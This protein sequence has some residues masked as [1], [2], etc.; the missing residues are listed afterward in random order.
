[1][2]RAGQR[3]RSQL[4][5]LDPSIVL[6]T[7]LHP[8]P[9]RPGLVE[10]VGL[11][12]Q[13]VES[14]ASVV[15]VVAPAGYGK[16]V[17]LS[18]YAAVVDRPFAWLSLDA[19]DTDPVLLA[20]ELATAIDRVA[21]V[22]ARVL[23]SLSSPAPAI[24]RVVLPGLVNSLHAAGNVALAVDDLHLVDSPGSVAVVSFLC[25]HLPPGAQLLVAS[26]DT[27]VLPLGALRVSGRLLELGWRDLML[28]RAEVEGVIRAT[29]AP[30]EGENLDSLHERTEGWPAAVYLAALAIRDG[31]E[32]LDS[33]IGVAGGD[34]DL[35]D[36]L[37]G[38]LLTRLPAERLSFLLR[39][40]VLDR[41]SA[42]LCDAV[43]GCQD[44]AQEIAELE[45]ANL[46]VQPLD[47]RREWYRYH[48]L[49]RDV[50]RAELAR[51]DARSVLSLHRRASRWHELEGTPEEAVQHALVAKDMRRAAD[52]V[53]EFGRR[54]I[55]VGRLATVR[56]WLGAFP[57]GEFAD[58]APLALT[59]AWVSALYG[60][61]DRARR[62]VSLAEHAPWRGRGPFDEPSLEA[63][64][65]LTRGVY[66]WEGVSRMRADAL[67]AYRLL[68]AG[69]RGH[70]PAAVAL[71]CSL[72][73]L[74]RTAEAV[75]FFEEGSALGAAR[76][77]ATLLALG[78]LAQID[79]E[80]GY[81]DAAEAKVRAGLALIAEQGLGDNTFSASVDTAA[82][83][84]GARSGD[85][86]RARVHLEKARSVLPRAAAAPWRSIRMRVLLGRA[87]LDLD[88]LPLAGTLL[89]EARRELAN[90]PDAGILPRLLA[91]EERALQAA[92]GGAG[93]LSEP[94]SA[95]ELKVLERLPTHLSLA[96]IGEALHISRNTVKAH[97]RSIY[98]K[99]HV[100][101][102][103]DAVE[104]AR[105]STGSWLA[106]A[107][108]P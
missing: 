73:L 101:V 31:G 65:A 60:E 104:R 80:E 95:A 35:V 22:D 99:L 74:G 42:P 16:T 79:L 43:L 33:G 46:F 57:E 25:E 88:D 100:G 36:Y 29:G 66:G 82:A 44:S 21:P 85:L 107:N 91:R 97:V 52:L 45:H 39:T 24:E 37:S 76:G 108:R 77:P 41:F 5:G 90:Y 32:G 11:L 48:H 63:A 58:S 93:V 89:E 47:R 94:L 54:L 83:C 105:A 78:V 92:R 86:T 17:L 51:W 9:A 38:E 68:P 15:V 84:L 8:R 28:S 81:L 59:A 6:E 75:P 4:P 19:T 1:M 40:S 96:E 3:P 103:A 14:E 13:L 49:F 18:Q 34:R 2:G 55:V 53:V 69:H 98:M 50:L 7:K 61:R 67:T 64:L 70:E 102:R 23:A 30:V 12:R 106:A 62:Y 20:L 56:R 87:A 26:R 10:R 71:G 72:M 27:S